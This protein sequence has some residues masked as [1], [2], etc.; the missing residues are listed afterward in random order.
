MFADGGFTHY[1]NK[2]HAASFSTFTIS[3]DIDVLAGS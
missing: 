2:F 3:Y 1:L